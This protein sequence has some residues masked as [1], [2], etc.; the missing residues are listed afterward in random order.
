MLI[1]L[2]PLAF[3][4][5]E[6]VLNL[7]LLPIPLI[8]LLFACSVIR[9]TV[10]ILSRSGPETPIELASLPF[11]SLFFGSVFQVFLG[12]PWFLSTH[13]LVVAHEEPL[14]LCLL[15]RVLLDR[16]SPETVDLGDASQASVVDQHQH[17][18]LKCVDVEDCQHLQEHWEQE[19]A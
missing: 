17:V 4:V 15:D 1:A 2:T 10:P 8:L 13:L 16:F 5:V 6:T 19:L 11:N 7:T 12:V 3:C 18:I 14:F 9:A